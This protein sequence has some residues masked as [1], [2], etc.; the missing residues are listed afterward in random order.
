MLRIHKLKI[1]LYLLAVIILTF[2]VASLIIG[3]T[4]A[5]S[6]FKD[7]NLTGCFITNID[8]CSKNLTNTTALCI[9]SDC[10]SAWPAG[11]GDASAGW[12]NTST[13]VQLA[14]ATDNISADVLF[15][16]ATSDRVGIGTTAPGAKLEVNG[17]VRITNDNSIDRGVTD[18]LLA[19][20]GGDGL[21]AGAE[22]VLIGE[23]RSSS[24][25]NAI[26]RHGGTPG[27]NLSSQFQV[28][29]RAND[30]SLTT[31]MVVNS[32][33]NVGIGTAAPG[34][35]GL[36]VM[37][38]NVGIGTSSPSGLLHVNGGDLIVNGTNSP[39]PVLFVDESTGNV[40][41]DSPAPSYRF[42]VKPGATNGKDVNLSSILYINS[43]SGNVGIGTTGPSTKLSVEG[44]IRTS[45]ALNVNGKGNVADYGDGA[46]T[47]KAASGYPLYLGANVVSNN[48]VIS[49]SGNVGIGTTS[50]LKKLSVNGD[51]NISGYFL[52]DSSLLPTVNVTTDFGNTTNW[53]DDAYID[54]IHITDIEIKSNITQRGDAD[55]KGQLYLDTN[56]RT[57]YDSS[58]SVYR[59]YNGTCLIDV[60]P[61]GNFTQC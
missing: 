39:I 33:G 43:T 4:E 25:G 21:G 26:I 34:T 6:S 12:K 18:S 23:S 13:Q 5:A 52:L 55:F 17:I 32:G 15:V 2:L 49:T 44:T 8:V 47:V 10:R 59:Y 54:N 46:F 1:L 14:D 50:P 41:I 19:L 56:M 7:I 53:I 60:L 30:S 37:N 27:S 51:V 48:L 3:S 40:G 42:E 57:F 9:G 58:N 45:E 11:G 24:P 36:A 31:Q 35:A 29:Y 61:T 22:L 16:D 38:G 28:Q 20:Y